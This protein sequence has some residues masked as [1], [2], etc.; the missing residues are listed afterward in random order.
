MRRKVSL[1]GR[2]KFFRSL[3]AAHHLPVLESESPIQALV[4][5]NAVSVRTL[6]QEAQAKG[7]DVRPILSPTVPQGQERIRICLH[8]YNSEDE[9]RELVLVLKDALAGLR[10]HER[11]QR[12]LRLV[13]GLAVADLALEQRLNGPINLAGVLLHI[14][15]ALLQDADLVIYFTA[16][17]RHDYRQP[18][19]AAD[20]ETEHGSL[21]DARWLLVW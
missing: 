19:H 1:H 8:L 11:T 15:L 17:H 12:L 5:P 2:V 16:A 7:F 4:V 9:I 20:R 10:H 14:T 6:A 21:L 18:Q 13:V 3:A